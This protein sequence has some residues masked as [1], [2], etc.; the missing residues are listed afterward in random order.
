MRH[1]IWIFTLGQSTCLPV[2][3]M[4]KVYIFYLDILP[5]EVLEMKILYCSLVCDCGISWSYS[6]F[7]L[8]MAGG[9]FLNKQCTLYFQATSV[10]SHSREDQKLVSKTDYCLMQVKS[11]LKESILQYFR[12]S[13]S[14]HLSLRA[15][16]FCLF[17]SGR[18]RL[19]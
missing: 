3:R 7:M 10:S 15:P 18:L 12:P 8:E 11:I 13:L 1:Y 5:I 2:Y 17:L 14:Y 16:L 19:V 6:F 4:K 9:K